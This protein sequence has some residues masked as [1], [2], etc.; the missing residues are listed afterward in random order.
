MSMEG[1]EPSTRCASNNR[2]TIE[3]HQLVHIFLY[4][5]CGLRPRLIIA[6]GGSE[7]ADSVTEIK[8]PIPELYC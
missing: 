1:I 7:S 6:L 5:A 4:C 3:L 8:S 2:S